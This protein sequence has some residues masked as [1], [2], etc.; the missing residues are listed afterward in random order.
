MR[1]FQIN[2]ERQPLQEAEGAT[3]DPESI[4]IQIAVPKVGQGQDGFESSPIDLSEIGRAYYSDSYISRAIDKVVGLM[5]KSGWGFSSLNQEALDYVNTRFKLM[6]ESTGLSTENLVRETGLNYVLYGNSPIIKVRDDANLAEVE[7]TGYL[8]ST[9]IGA[10]FAAPPERIQIERDEMGNITN[11]TILDDTGGENDFSPED[12]LMMTYHKPTG[13]A[14]G[15]PYITNV[16]DDVLILRQ[17][18]ENVS[19]LIYRNIFPLT[20]YTVGKAEPGYE[21]TEEEIAEVRAQIENAPLDS[22][23]VMPERHSM[24]TVSNSSSGLDASSY[25][26]Y[27]RQRVFT[28]LG[29]SE[30][31]MGIGDTANRSTSDNQS[32]DLIDLVKD[33]QQNFAVEFQKIINEILFEGGYDPTLNKEDI[34]RFEFTEIEQAAKI[35]RENH[36]IQMFHGNAI[37]FEELRT[38]NGDEPEPDLE[39]FYYN[40]FK[41]D[42]TSAAEASQNATNNKDQPENQHG[43]QD[44]PNSDSLKDEFDATNLSISEKLRLTD[45]NLMVNVSIDSVQKEAKTILKSSWNEVKEELLE[46]KAFFETNRKQVYRLLDKHISLSLFSNKE[47]KRAYLKKIEASLWWKLNHNNKTEEIFHDSIYG[48]ENVLANLYEKEML[49][50]FSIKSEEEIDDID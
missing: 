36:N 34:V 30:S 47:S 20:T 21:A 15:V 8:D 42:A 26:K 49:N 43:K 2:N 44:A 17:I 38:R 32:S 13:R 18:E 28:G 9:P 48:Y 41:T 1:M 50:E 46:N 12:V 4:R 37:S 19:R 27:F 40:L 16:L 7:A 3:R 14:F 11:Y 23:I 25:L 5:F 22:T 31:G 29:V 10:L 33:F 6:E 45:K 39:R 35:A 24:E